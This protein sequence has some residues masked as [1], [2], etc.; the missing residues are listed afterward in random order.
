[1]R[2]GGNLDGQEGPRGLIGHGQPAD[3]LAGGQGHVLDGVDLPDLVGMDGL[4]DHR[5]DRTAA[6]RSMDSGADEG[7]LEGPDRRE[8]APGRVPAELEADQPGAPAGM[9]ALQVTGDPE[10][11]PDPRGDRTTT[12]AIVGGQV[13][14]IAAAG[15]PPDVSDRGV[16]DRQVGGDPGQELALLM[17]SHDLL[18]ERD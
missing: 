2:W 1:L 6:P 9:V 11:L 5:G 13:R 15:Q 16:G 10:Q 3:P 8:V 7:A 12:R 4:G 17:T 18:T 14:A